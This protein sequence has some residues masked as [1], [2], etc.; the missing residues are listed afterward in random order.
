MVLC[1]VPLRGGSHVS[2]AAE[3]SLLSLVSSGDHPYA[4]GPATI[5]ATFVAFDLSSFPALHSYTPAASESFV[6][7]VCCVPVR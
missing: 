2:E 4:V 1:T 6:L 5:T 3:S 7:A